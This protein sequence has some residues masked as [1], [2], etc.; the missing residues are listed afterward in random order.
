MLMRRVHKHVLTHRKLIGDGGICANLEAL[1][2][3]GVP[4]RYSDVNPGQTSSTL[5]RRKSRR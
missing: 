3:L 5:F 1:F 2:A 4:N